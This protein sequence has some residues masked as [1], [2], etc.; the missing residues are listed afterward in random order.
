MSFIKWFYLK[1]KKKLSVTENVLSGL[2][3][4]LMIN[5]SVYV[6]AKI[7]KVFAWSLKY[8]TLK[9]NRTIYNYNASRRAGD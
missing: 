7:K 6:L 9:P 1:N 2:L 4:D 8:E 5:A 3:L